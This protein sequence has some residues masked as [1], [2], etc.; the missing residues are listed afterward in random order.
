MNLT[1]K[2]ISLDVRV[3][4]VAIFLTKKINQIPWLQFIDKLKASLAQAAN[5]PILL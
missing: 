5:L 1:M 4:H 2:R 3:F